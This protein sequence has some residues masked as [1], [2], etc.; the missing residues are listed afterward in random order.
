VRYAGWQDQA[1]QLYNLD[2]QSIKDLARDH[3]CAMT[4]ARPGHSSVHSPW[5]ASSPRRCASAHPRGSVSLPIHRCRRGRS[6]TISGAGRAPWSGRIAPPPAQPSTCGSMT[7]S[8]SRIV[9]EVGNE[10]SPW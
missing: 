2:R 4:R 1:V 10:R 9:A 8:M 6:P 5:N 7:E 3:V